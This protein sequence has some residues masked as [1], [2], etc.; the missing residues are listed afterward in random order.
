RRGIELPRP[1]VVADSWFSDSKLMHR[2]AATHGGTLLVEGKSTYIFELADGRQVKGSALQQP[3]EWLWRDS[4]RPLGSSHCSRGCTACFF[5]RLRAPLR[6][7]WGP[8]MV[9]HISL[10]S[11]PCCHFSGVHSN[12]TLH[13]PRLISLPPHGENHLSPAHKRDRPPPPPRCDP[14]WP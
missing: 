9:R 5:F 12:D 7:C 14:P 1:M 2:V 4:P 3:N 10:G 11:P 8:P 13:T 6:S